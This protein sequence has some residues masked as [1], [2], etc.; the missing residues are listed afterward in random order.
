[1]KRAII[2]SSRI[3]ITIKTPGNEKYARYHG[4]PAARA[5]LY[6]AK[7]QLPKIAAA[8]R[9][10]RYCKFL[11]SNVHFGTLALQQQGEVS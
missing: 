8:M 2:G 6:S 10:E 9:T 1:M 3:S 5:F 4:S 11:I 7:Y